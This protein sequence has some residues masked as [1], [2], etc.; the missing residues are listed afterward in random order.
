[1]TGSS[2]RAP[3]FQN[4]SQTVPGD[5]G[6][7]VTAETTARKSVNPPSPSRPVGT[8]RRRVAAVPPNDAGGGIAA[9]R[10]RWGRRSRRLRTV[11]EAAS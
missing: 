4:A 6:D 5:G 11:A 3:F 2:F 9:R 10:E 7:G 8:F 1:M